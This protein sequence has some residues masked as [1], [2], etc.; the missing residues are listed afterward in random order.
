MA[1]IT[2]PDAE[3]ARLLIRGGLGHCVE[4]PD[5]TRFKAHYDQACAALLARAGKTSRHPGAG[6]APSEGVAAQGLR[7]LTRMIG[8]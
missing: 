6:A 7:W 1:G 2:S 3:H 5:W 8:R 4:I